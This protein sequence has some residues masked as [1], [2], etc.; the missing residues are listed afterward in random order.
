MEYGFEMISYGMMY[1]QS[2]IKTNAGFQAI[3]MLTSEM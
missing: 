1:V 3:L 2:F